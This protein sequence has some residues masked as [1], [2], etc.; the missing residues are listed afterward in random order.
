VVSLTVLKPEPL[1]RSGLVQSLKSH[2]MAGS[3]KKILHYPFEFE[4][5]R[6]WPTVDR[7]TNLLLISKDGRECDAA[8]K[9]F[10]AVNSP[11]RMGYS[12]EFIHPPYDRHNGALT[13]DQS[14]YPLSSHRP[15]A[16]HHGM[17]SGIIL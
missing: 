5:Y 8:G 4:A 6:I 12:K 16:S 15:A 13:S 14:G 17:Q 10:P 9:L 3:N 11:C 7:N 2:T 1:P